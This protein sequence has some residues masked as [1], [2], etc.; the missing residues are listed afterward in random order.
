MAQDPPT[1]EFGRRGFLLS[2]SGSALLGFGLRAAAARGSAGPLYV[3]CR[4]DGDGRFFTSGFRADGRTVF[5]LLLPGRGHAIS[6][7]PGT[8]HCVV[9]ARRPGRFAVVLDAAE[10]AALQRIDA[11]AGRH[12]YGH[13]TYSAD[14]RY[15]LTTENDYE[16]GRG[17]IGV[18]DAADHYRQIGELPSFGIGPHEATLMPDGKTLAIAN[19]GVRTHPDYDRLELNLDSMTPSLAY[20]ELAGGRMLGEVQ[21]PHQLHQ[22]SIRHVTVNAAGLVAVAMQYEGSKRDQVPLVGLDDGKGELRLL[23]APPDILRRMR[24]YTGAIAFD[25]GGE[26]LAV[27]SPRGNLFTFWDARSGSLVDHVELADGCG[28]TPA[29]TPGAFLVSDGRGQIL[30]VEPR[31]RRQSPVPIANQL[32]T[33]WDNHLATARLPDRAV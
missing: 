15:L 31:A 17:V 6:F 11:A 32:V 26:L 1:L 19:G 13:G 18:R 21:L 33:P 30:R 27:S 3:G 8:A 12:F 7:R 28:L 14:G 25:P 16:A 10:G 4:I 20:L 9:Y 5:D 2:L 29:D 23:Q 22:L 24:Q